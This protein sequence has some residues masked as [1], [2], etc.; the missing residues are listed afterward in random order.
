MYVCGSKC[1]MCACASWRHG[2]A[3][4]A[5]AAAAS[6]KMSM[7]TIIRDKKVTL[8]PSTRRSVFKNGQGG[9]ETEEHKTKTKWREGREKH[10][11]T[12]R[13]QKA[14]QRTG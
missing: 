6:S 3:Y 9:K 7:V 2:P 4:S 13:G 12:R 11:T 1:I 8:I 5:K 14:R 10:L